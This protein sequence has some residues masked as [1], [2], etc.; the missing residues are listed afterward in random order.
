MWEVRHPTV[1]HFLDLAIALA[2]SSVWSPWAVLSTSAVMLKAVLGT[3]AV[4]LKAV[5]G[6]SAVM[7]K[8]VLSISA[9]MLSPQDLVKGRAVSLV[10]CFAWA[11]SELHQLTPSRHR[12]EVW[13]YHHRRT[14][15]HFQ[16]VC[17][18]WG[19]PSPTINQLS[20]QAHKLALLLNH[21]MEEKTKTLFMLL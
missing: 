19:A 11:A 7:L 12:L 5:Q 14:Q 20:L 16:S 4:M 9:V 13:H 21:Q 10:P 3:S 18:G 8:T 15:Q 17:H 6:T 1:L 2:W